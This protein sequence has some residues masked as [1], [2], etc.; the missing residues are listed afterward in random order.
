MISYSYDFYFLNLWY[1]PTR[2]SKVHEHKRPPVHWE[3]ECV[4]TKKGKEWSES[5]E[6]G[7]K[8]DFNPTRF[9]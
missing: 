3:E 2:Q 8:E 1:I 5:I 9:A 4:R 7:M 6:S